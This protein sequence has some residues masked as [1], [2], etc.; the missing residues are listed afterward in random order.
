MSALTES[1][2]FR[3]GFLMVGLL[4]VAV[5]LYSSVLAAGSTDLSAD[6]GST[7][8]D[9]SIS[10]TVPAGAV[11]E[12]STLSTSDSAVSTALPDGVTAGS[13]AFEMTLSGDD[14]FSDSVFLVVYSST[15]SRLVCHL[16]I[17]NL[18]C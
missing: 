12:A 13:V 4:F 1:R 11:S 3:Y 16:Y 15:G 7:L 14:S 9:G 18:L 2:G 17:W 6:S 5:S 8:T 10:I